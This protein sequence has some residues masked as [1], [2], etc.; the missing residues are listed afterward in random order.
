ML[1]YIICFQTT[2][3]V[4]AKVMSGSGLPMLIGTHDR[5]CVIWG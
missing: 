2:L 3:P 1:S 4:E 5:H